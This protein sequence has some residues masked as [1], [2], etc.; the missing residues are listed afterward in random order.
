M[1]GSSPVVGSSNRM[2]SGS[3]TTALA[4]ATRRTIPP[5]SS[6]GYFSDAPSSPTVRRIPR[7]FSRISPS[8]IFVF[9]R[10][11]NATFS[12]TVRESKSAPD[13]NSIP[14]RLRIS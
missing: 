11:G 1:I 14:N 10:S 12:N 3:I 4:S 7:T 2:I 9:S 5:E 13:W 8:A 6:S